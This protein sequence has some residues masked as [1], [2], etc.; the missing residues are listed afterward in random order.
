MVGRA[1]QICINIHPD[2]VS[3]IHAESYHVATDKPP[4]P[5]KDGDKFRSI[6][7]TVYNQSQLAE[8]KHVARYW[9]INTVATAVPLSA[10]PFPLVITTKLAA[11]I[12]GR[13]C[14]AEVFCWP[15]T[16]PVASTVRWPVVL[17]KLKLVPVS[18]YMKHMNTGVTGNLV[19]YMCA[20]NCFNS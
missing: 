18:D 12:F 16:T 6:L 11:A 19:K 9:L 5:A 1:P 2:A 3:P 17:L 20:K 8:R 13:G 14:T 7:A 10:H 15:S 4:P